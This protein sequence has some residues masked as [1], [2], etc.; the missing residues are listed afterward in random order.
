MSFAFRGQ[1]VNDHWPILNLLSFAQ[2][3]DQRFHVVTINIADV[4]EAK[5]VDERARQDRRGNSILHRFRGR[6]QTLADGWN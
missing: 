4:F 3:F 2:R 5:F 1:R 6:V